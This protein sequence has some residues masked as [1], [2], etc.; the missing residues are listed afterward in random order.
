MY[1]GI[2]YFQ[3]LKRVR[4]QLNELT[5]KFFLEVQL[6]DYLNEALH[7][8]GDECGYL[9]DVSYE[10]VV[11]STQSYRVPENVYGLDHVMFKKSAT[12]RYP[13]TPIDMKMDDEISGEDKTAEGDP[14]HFFRIGD[15]VYLRPVPDTSYTNGLEFWGAHY[16]AN[17][18]RNYATGTVSLTATATVLGATTLWDNNDNAAAGCVLGIGTEPKIWYE[19][20]SIDSD[21]ELTLHEAYPGPAAVGQSYVICD[22]PKIEMS[23]HHLLE[24]YAIGQGLLRERTTMGLGEQRMAEFYALLRSGKAS[25]RRKKSRGRTYSIRR[26]DKYPSRKQSTFGVR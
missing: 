21:T 18:F 9:D 7:I 3:L 17:M 13:L 4:T 12:E 16:P 10:N 25:T 23:L 5:E 20:N 26:R 1:H 11:A 14:A 24:K 22:V 19:I 8:V 6:Q 15:Y 2:P